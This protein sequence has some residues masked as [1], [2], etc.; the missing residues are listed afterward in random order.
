MQSR[1]RKFFNA[2]YQPEYAMRTEDWLAVLFI[3]GGGIIG[4]AVGMV[5]GSIV[6]YT[7]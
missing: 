4:F 1:V 6:A 7:I 5:I 3:A 2:W